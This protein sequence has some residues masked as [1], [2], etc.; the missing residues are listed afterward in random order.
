MVYRIFICHAYDHRDI[1]EELRI[2]LN[3]QSRFDWRNLSVQYDMRY[4]S[5]DDEIDQ[6]E[7]RELISKRIHECDI[8]L[9]L[10]KPIASRRKWLQWEIT[11][12]KALGKPVI[13]I[14]RRRND[15]VSR[16][17]REHADDIVDTWR[18]DHIVNAIEWRVDE[19]RSRPPPQVVDMSE[20][21]PLP[22]S[23]PDEELDAEPTPDNAAELGAATTSDHTVIET[24]S[25]EQSQALPR[26]VLYR[27]L[28]AFVPQSIASP[29]N[30]PPRWWW[31]F[32][33]RPG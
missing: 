22:I 6:G 4:G 12:A 13:G 26:D 10:T 7:L 27:D 17:V 30:R 11:R 28:G 32:T 16:F 18:V 9:A 20:L 3:G 1:Y 33:Q 23:T 19:C 14:A 25:R 15:R 29:R 24:P 21:P 31:P 2:K 5:V 8:L